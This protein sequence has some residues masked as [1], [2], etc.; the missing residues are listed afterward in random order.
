MHAGLLG[1]LANHP[2]VYPERLMIYNAGSLNIYAVTFLRQFTLLSYIGCSI[3]FISADAASQIANVV[4]M[5]SSVVAQFAIIHAR[6][7]IY[8]AAATLLLTMH[9]VIIGGA[10]PM[11]A[12]GMVLAPYVAH[13]FLKVPREARTSKEALMIWAKRP[14]PH[15][16]MDIVHTQFTGWKKTTAVQL[17]DLRVLPSGRGVTPNLLRLRYG[18][19][20]EVLPDEQ[21]WWKV[22]PRTRYYVQDID[23][24]SRKSAAPG[25]WKLVWQRIQQQSGPLKVESGQGQYHEW[26]ARRRQSA[27]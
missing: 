26:K 8:H 24:V 17:K 7:H 1:E 21:K 22:G 11:I 19:H 12:V 27:T 15:I 18:R 23:L 6:T 5:G 25:V 13:I 2:V 14:P 20:G 9:P 10:L 16:Q 4:G 3:F